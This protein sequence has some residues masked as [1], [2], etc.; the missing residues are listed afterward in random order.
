MEVYNFFFEIVLLSAI[1]IGIITIIFLVRR[2]KKV[3][4]TLEKKE[5]TE[6]IPDI[7]VEKDS[8]SK[9]IHIGVLL[10]KEILPPQ[11]GETE[12]V[13]T[14]IFVENEDVLVWVCPNCETENRP[15]DYQCVVCHNAR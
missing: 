2:R 12:H 4:D 3:E 15:S 10:K 1:A 7:K 9:E 13:I 14:T 11:K 5:E 8:D 6:S